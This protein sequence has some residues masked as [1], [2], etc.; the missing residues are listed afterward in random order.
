MPKYPFILILLLSLLLAGCRER[1]VVILL[2]TPIDMDVRA[3]ELV[4]TQNA[5]PPGFDQVSYARIDDGLTSLS[6]WRYRAALDF[7]GVF[8]QIPDRRTTASTR[9]EVWYNQVGSAR[10]VVADLV[11]DVQAQVEPVSYEAVRLGP[12][13]F[14]VRDGTCLANAGEDAATAADIGAGDIVG[15]VIEA[16]PAAQRAIINE[17]EVWRY[18][19]GTGQII[20]PSLHLRPDSVIL[21]AI[22]EL[23]VAPELGVPVRYYLTL[24]VENVSLFEP[25]ALPVSGTLSLRYDLYDV[26][27]VPNISVPFGC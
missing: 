10:R 11:S 4:L 27:V 18:S 16:T 3:T 6:G 22:G 1:E 17:Q 19:F 23:W 15:G 24:D 21:N 26:G 13:A 8:A 5:P 9:I 2:P 12:D 20:L 25:D 7:N 14:L